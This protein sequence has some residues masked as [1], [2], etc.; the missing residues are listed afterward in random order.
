MGA[1]GGAMT[2]TITNP[3]HKAHAAPRCHAKSK[4][5]GER[6]KAPAVRGKR[7]CRMHG[8]RAGAPKGSKH[9]MY[10]HGARTQQATLRK[11]ALRLLMSMSRDLIGSL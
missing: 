6:C 10:K 9:G 7:V 1:E 2:K 5:S 8:A 11:R 4:R 3:M